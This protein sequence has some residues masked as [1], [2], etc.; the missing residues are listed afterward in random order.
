M[1]SSD[2]LNYIGAGLDALSDKAKK[3]KEIDPNDFGSQLEPNMDIVHHYNPYRRTDNVEPLVKGFPVIFITT[4]ALNFEDKNVE[5]DSF[6]T[7]CKSH[8]PE[9]LKD[10]SFAEPNSISNGSPFIKIFTNKFRSFST[11]D[12]QLRTKELNET[13]YGMKQLYPSAIVDSITADELSIKYSE[14][15]NLDIIKRHKVWV[16][17]TENLRRGQYVPSETALNK[18]YIDFTSSLYYFLLDFDFE[19]ILYFAKYTGL[20]PVN[21][22][23][24]AL[25]GEFNSKELVDVDIN[26]IYSYKEDLDPYILMDFQF[27]CDKIEQVT[28]YNFDDKTPSVELPENEKPKAAYNFDPNKKNISSVKIYK[29]TLS[30]Y[31]QINGFTTSYGPDK[32]IVYKL[33]FIGEEEKTEL[34]AFP[35]ID[36]YKTEPKIK[37]EQITNRGYKIIKDNEGIKGE[38][39]TNREY[40]IIKDGE[41]I[42]GEQITNREYKIIKDDEVKGEQITS[43]YIKEE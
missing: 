21:V 43:R 30:N 22:P 12:T 36:G 20:V 13:F 8:E 24:S 3:D 1:A 14:T 6:L 35:A 37:G 33:K 16:E 17:Y 11:K 34:R 9:I 18:R 39:I 31:D 27:L 19:T 25:S 29:Q 2:I 23:Y 10:L 7:Y 32:K 40:K 4:P 42:K 5:K 38:E 28:A 15:K 26:Y 41:E